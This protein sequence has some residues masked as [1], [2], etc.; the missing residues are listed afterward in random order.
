MLFPSPLGTWVQSQPKAQL[1]LTDQNSKHRR[2]CFSNIDKTTD[3]I[4][5]FSQFFSS[6]MTIFSPSLQIHTPFK[7]QC[8][9]QNMNGYNHQPAWHKA[10][11]GDRNRTLCSLWRQRK[12]T[13]GHQPRRTHCTPIPRQTPVMGIT[14]KHSQRRGNY[15]MLLLAE[16][17]QELQARTHAPFIRHSRVRKENPVQTK[18]FFCWSC[19]SDSPS[20][21]D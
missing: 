17:L 3:R 12:G 8:T 14:W 1:A 16:E 20:G 6:P 11:N 13:E 5:V 9:S 2:I 19:N 21:I 18:L 7:H 15:V 10:R 4:P